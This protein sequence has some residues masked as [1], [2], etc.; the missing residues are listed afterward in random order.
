M[1]GVDIESVWQQGSLLPNQS[2]GGQRKSKYTVPLGNAGGGGGGGGPVGYDF[3]Q[4]GQNQGGN[5]SPI[6]QQQYQQ[7]QHQPQQF[8]QSPPISSQQE[9]DQY[10]QHSSQPPINLREYYSQQV[11][12]QYRANAS[13]NAPPISAPL[14]SPP[15]QPQPQPLPYQPNIDYEKEL[16]NLKSF[17]YQL[18]K[19]LNEIKHKQSNTNKQTWGGILWTLFIIL[20]L[21]IVLVILAQI[22]KKLNVLLG[23]SIDLI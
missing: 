14:P 15:P 3:Q 12:I 13:E 19:E 2:G 5:Y 7:Q 18:K 8:A 10:Q 9:Y 16:Y 6:Q 4:D 11:P 22:M 20:I 17:I 21:I 1:I 23:R